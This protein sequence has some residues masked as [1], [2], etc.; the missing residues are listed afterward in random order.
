[1]GNNLSKIIA[2]LPPEIKDDE[3]VTVIFHAIKL[4]FEAKKTM[5]KELDI[6]I[7]IIYD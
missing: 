5:K 2:E 6:Y 4:F 1:M 3:R 7:Y